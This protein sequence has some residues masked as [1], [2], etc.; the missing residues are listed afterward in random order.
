MT[1]RP[2]SRFAALVLILAGLVAA[3]CAESKD[4]LR[5]RDGLL[6]VGLDQN[7]FLAEWG[8][9]DRTASAISE[10]QLRARWGPALSGAFS[11]GFFKGKRPLDVW[12]YERHGVELVFDDG[13]LVAWRTDK[14]VEQLRAIPARKP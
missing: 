1:Q 7:A 11:G 13:D 5:V 8:P 6:M 12:S 10:E 3:G 2:G 4:R 9:P 14:T